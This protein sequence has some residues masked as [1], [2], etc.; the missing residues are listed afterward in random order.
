MLLD[1]EIASR[2][3]AA[4]EVR[5]YALA[6]ESDARVKQRR[7]ER[8][9]YTYETRNRR[10]Y[11]KKNRYQDRRLRIQEFDTKQWF[12]LWIPLVPLAS[13]RIRRRFRPWWNPC[14][15]NRL[16]IL[17][18]RP[19]DWQ[20]ILRTWGQAALVLVILIFVVEFGIRKY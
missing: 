6:I 14:P 17:E 5:S 20:Q 18:T 1:V 10:F 8:S 2:G 16:H 9:R 4:D 15:V 12:V 3:I 19:R 13:Y 7:R 11:G